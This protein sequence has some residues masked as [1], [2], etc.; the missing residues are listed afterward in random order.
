M[1]LFY[2]APVT[3]S[4][5]LLLRSDYHLTWVDAATTYGNMFDFL[6]SNGV[7]ACITPV[8]S[9]T[10]MLGEN[11]CIPTEGGIIK[12]NWTAWVNGDNYENNIS[13]HEAARV[14]IL[15]GLDLFIKK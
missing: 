15:K 1:T 8:N 6:L 14:A 4:L 10:D 5:V 13:W 3:A 12:T 9:P 7:V 2:S 11:G